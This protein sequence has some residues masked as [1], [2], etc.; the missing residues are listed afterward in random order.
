MSTFDWQTL[1]PP[2]PKK[3]WAEKAQ[4]D[5]G[6]ETPLRTLTWSPPGE[7]A[8]DPYYTRHDLSNQPSQTL[9]PLPSR[10][11]KGWLVCEPVSAGSSHSKIKQ[12]IQ[13]AMG[14]GAQ[15]LLF[16]DHYTSI[17]GETL[18][19]LTQNGNRPYFS[20]LS[21]SIP[22]SERLAFADSLPPDSFTI[23]LLATPDDL[24]SQPAVDWAQHH[25]ARS[26]V[27]KSAHHTFPSVVEELHHLTARAEGMFNGLMASGMD[28]SDI[29]NRCHLFLQIGSSFYLEIAKFRAARWLTGLIA[30]DIA[31]DHAGT[32][33]IKITADT[34]TN[35][36]TE[37][38]S[39]ANLL[40]TTTRAMSA[41]IGGCDAL[42]IRP[43]TPD[44]PGPAKRWARNI[45][46][47]LRHEAHLDKVIDL[48]A[49]AYYI[50]TI[51][52]QLVD[53]VWRLYKSKN[54]RVDIV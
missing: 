29:L 27:L 24:K 47:I 26:I 41:V 7:L 12:E 46:H 22:V 16:E 49:G 5:L 40:R 34:T 42:V 20:F 39:H 43:H 4:R 54:Q 33:P 1:F 30:K 21:S 9:Q 15:V 23:D 28:I 44:A 37:D 38:D 8:I 50:E 51:T 52:R 32:L 11:G 6:P 3:T 19:D 14:G 18:E 48:G 13:A 2:V 45:H 25:D 35:G 36:F 31:D 53:R 10:K 17:D